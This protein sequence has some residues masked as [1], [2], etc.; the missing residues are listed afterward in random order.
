MIGFLWNL[1]KLFRYLLPFLYEVSDERLTDDNDDK[2]K[3]RKIRTL[4]RLILYRFIFFIIF[5]ISVFY[6]AIPLYTQSK[7]L[8]QE[9]RD[10]E[11]QV[12]QKNLEVRELQGLL[13]KNN[14]TITTKTIELTGA[15]EEQKRLANVLAECRVSESTLRSELMSNVLSKR[16]IP[17]RLKVQ[18]V[19]NLSKTRIQNIQ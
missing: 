13:R 2:E 10:L 8:Q 4:L 5:F 7:I 9:V 14:D 3:A 12:T 6:F 19:S 18:P 1:F 17:D 11:D 16:K 15:I